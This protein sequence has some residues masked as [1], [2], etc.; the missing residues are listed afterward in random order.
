[1][2]EKTVMRHGIADRTTLPRW[3]P[4]VVTPSAR[5]SW[6]GRWI[7]ASCVLALVAGCGGEKPVT[8]GAATEDEI[9]ALPDDPPAETMYEIEDMYLGI[10]GIPLEMLGAEDRDRANRESWILL[11]EI[12][13]TEGIVTIVAA[14]DRGASLYFSGGGALLGE[15]LAHEEIGAKAVELVAL[16]AEL[17]EWGTAT[18]EFPLPERDRVRFHFAGPGASRTCDAPLDELDAGDHEL[19]PLFAAAV[20]LASMI[21]NAAPPAPGAAGDG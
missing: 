8:A 14:G 20:E 13:D 11:T 9:P 7:V 5:P 10:R 17:G 19:S 3:L 4:R 12:G 15:G 2:G 16:A 21:S 6:P 1:M 18:S